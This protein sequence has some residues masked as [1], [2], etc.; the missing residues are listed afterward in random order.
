MTPRPHLTLGKD[1]I[2]ILHEAGWASGLVWI[3]AENLSPPEFDPRTVQPVGSRY[4][5][6][7]TRP[8]MYIS[9]L[10]H[11]LLVA[12]PFL[13]FPILLGTLTLNLL[14]TTIVAPPSNASKWQMGFNSAFKGLRQITFIIRFCLRIAR[15]FVTVLAMGNVI[16]IQTFFVN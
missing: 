11:F 4:T 7:A 3:G 16:F 12:S 14:T 1:P 8:T 9:N 15:S 5:D 13:K 10:L 2:P 6:Y